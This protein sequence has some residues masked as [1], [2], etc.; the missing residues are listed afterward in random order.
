MNYSDL[1]SSAA[2]LLRTSSIEAER[3]IITAPYRYKHYK[4]EKRNGGQRDIH[5]P[6]PALKAIQ[7]WLVSTPL[8]NLPVHD[9]VYSY[10]KGRNIAMH[11][12]M[13]VESNYITRFD[14]SDFF[15][16]IT[17]TTIRRF[18]LEET[19]KGTIDLDTAAINA[20][21]RLVCR[22]EDKSGKLVLSIGAPSSPHLSNAV[23]HDFDHVM[24]SSARIAGG[25]YTRYADDIYVS[26]RTKETVALL[27]K[28]F[29]RET[30][31]LLPYLKI[32]ERKTQRLSRK[33][34][35]AVTGINVTPQRKLS[36]GRDL[37]RSLKTKVHLALLGQ[38]APEELSALRGMIAHVASV[39]PAFMD[40]LS[41]KFGVERLESFL[42]SR[43]I[44][45]VSR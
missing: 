24:E 11:A 38:I 34:R 6:T 10:R 20:I 16:S 15:P 28:A 44:E 41:K 2:K 37:K 43:E 42:T 12:A 27:E 14:F 31:K 8:A 39:E 9:C 21:V 26:G 4:I 3:I 25:M 35:M 23:L 36:V 29:I 33:R 45:E 19:M 7:R 32:N 18:L 5:H 40:S 30:S 17:A 1:L 22:A 13:H